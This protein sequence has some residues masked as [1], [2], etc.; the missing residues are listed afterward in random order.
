MTFKDYLRVQAVLRATAAREGISV[1]E[2]KRNIQEAID[3]AWADPAG[4]EA[5][6]E[7]FPEGKPTPEE[8]IVRLGKRI[9]GA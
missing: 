1:A 4:R 2:V 8:M 7:L 3:A 9:G 6:Q 5:Q